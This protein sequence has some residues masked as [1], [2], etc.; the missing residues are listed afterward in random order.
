M[1][2]QFFLTFLLFL[3][4]LGVF[5]Q[6]WSDCVYEKPMANVN[7]VSISDIK[8]SGWALYEPFTDDFN[9]ST[10]DRLKWSP[11]DWQCHDM[12]ELAY[13]R[14]QLDNVKVENG[15]LLLRCKPDTAWTCGDPPITRNFSSG[16]VSSKYTTRFGYIEV[17]CKLPADINLN[18]CFWTYGTYWPD[19]CRRYDEIDVNEYI[20]YEGSNQ[21][22]RQSILRKYDYCAENTL[23]V[24]CKDLLFSQPYTNQDIIFGLEW[25][26]TEINFF[27]N[28]LLTNSYKYTDIDEWVSP[29]NYPDRS[30][31]TCVDFTNGVAQYI[32]LS[33]SLNPYDPPINLAQGWSLDWVRSFKLVQ[34][35]NYEWN[36]NYISLNDP[37]LTRVHKV[38]KIGGYGHSGDIPVNSNITL[39][40]EDYVYLDENFSLPPETE[41]TVRAI[42]TAPELFYSN[43]NLPDPQTVFNPD[44]VFNPNSY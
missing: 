20:P 6:M 1:K 10:L 35:F 43:S 38:V 15:S 26:P 12:S 29:G 2:K 30:V 28:G 24:E 27:V 7:L 8:A 22:F 23:Q 36:P 33:L 17:K 37:N 5:S 44:K 34:G 41:F 31:F 42:V 11:V 14:D 16:Y 21:T 9:T 4:S 32:F 3:L 25:L 13:F 18:P 39:W 40:G 19:H